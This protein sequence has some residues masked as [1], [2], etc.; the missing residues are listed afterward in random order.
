[1]FVLTSWEPPVCDYSC[2]VQLL[3]PMRVCI[4]GLVIGL[5]L[6][7]LIHFLF[8]PTAPLAVVGMAPPVM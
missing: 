1:M 6:Y 3:A 2:P 5:H 8:F 7:L 4:C